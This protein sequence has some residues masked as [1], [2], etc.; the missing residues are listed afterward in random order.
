MEAVL[1]YPMVTKHKSEVMIWFWVI[2][3]IAINRFTLW[4][5]LFFNKHELK[6][7]SKET[8]IWRSLGEL[9]KLYKQ[10][11]VVTNELRTCISLL[12]SYA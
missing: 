6:Y 7:F 4:L 5:T 3:L 12:L 9:E 11:G 8:G 1:I 2:H 10:L